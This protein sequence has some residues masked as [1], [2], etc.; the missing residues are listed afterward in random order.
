MTMEYQRKMKFFH[1]PMVKAEID[2]LDAKKDCQ[3]IV[4]LL[5]SYEFS[6]DIARG[7]ELAILYT[8]AS[9]RVSKLLDHTKEF[10]KHG[11]KRIEDTAIL[12]ALFMENGWQNETGLKSIKRINRTHGHYRIENDDFIFVLWTFIQFPITWCEKYGRRPLS[13]HEQ[14]AWINFWLGI[15]HHMDIKDVPA[16]QQGLDD[17]ILRYEKQHFSYDIANQNVT[18]ATLSLLKLRFPPEFGN[19]IEQVALAMMPE[20]FFAAVGYQKPHFLVRFLTQNAYRTIGYLNK[21]LVIGP[22]P[23]LIRKQ[24]LNTQQYPFNIDR[25]VPKKLSIIE[26]Q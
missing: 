6:F 8:Y 23:N 5:K 13:T 22:Y 2:R 14:T 16:T 17:W 3:R 12:I 25:L 1:N 19:L 26:N 11:V 4:Y 7:L 20:P 21:Y 18:E 15:A 10:K 24:K 9:P